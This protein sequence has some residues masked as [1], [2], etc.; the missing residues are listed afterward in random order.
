MHYFLGLGVWQRSYDIFLS[1][2]KYIVEILNRFGMMDC[3]S[4]A[5][6]MLTNLKKLS[7]YA[8]DS[9]LVDPTMYRKLIGSL[10]YLVNNR[11]Y[12][13]FVVCTLIQFMVEMGHVHW[14]ASKHVLIYLRGTIRFGLRY[15][16]SG[17]VRLQRYTILTWGGECNGWKENLQVLLQL[18]INYDILVQKEVDF[19]ST[20]YKRG[21]VYHNEC[22]KSQSNVD[23]EASCRTI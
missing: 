19:C 12:V 22:R 23:L 3:K 1:Q 14:V 8:L 10:M 11:P 6:P 2:G 9:Y 4:M 13:F 21:R 16:S 17:E 7:D 18:W 20:Q 15:V 5:T